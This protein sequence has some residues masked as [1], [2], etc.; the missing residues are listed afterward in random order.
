MSHR[1]H[2]N[3]SKEPLIRSGIGSKQSRRCLGCGRGKELFLRNMTEF[4]QTCEKMLLE[5]HWCK[6]KKLH[7]LCD[8][9][10]LSFVRHADVKDRAEC[11][12]ALEPELELV[13]GALSAIPSARFLSWI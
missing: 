2:Q 6:K 8:R 3:L 1:T 10:T 7:N 5:D 11:V 4:L 12:L 9:E 13:K